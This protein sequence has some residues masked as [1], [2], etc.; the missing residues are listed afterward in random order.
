MLLPLR[1]A[2]STAGLMLTTEA[3]IADIKEDTKQAAA[4]AG[5]HGGGPGRGMGGMYWVSLNPHGITKGVP[6][7]LGRPF[8]YQS[9]LALFPVQ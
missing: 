7:Q 8:S 4:G 1:N 9:V 2:A 3:L 5:G 6:T